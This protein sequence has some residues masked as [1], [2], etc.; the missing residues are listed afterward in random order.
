MKETIMT[1]A[2]E[3]NCEA[4][5]QQSDMLQMIFASLPVGIMV[6]DAEG[7]LLFFNPAA[8]GIL[9]LGVSDIP[10]GRHAPIYGW[11]LPDQITVL[12]NERLPLVR[13]IRGETLADEVIFVRNL[14]HPEGT[15]IRVS[16]G[17]LRNRS[18]TVSGGVVMLHDFSKEREE[19]Q[20]LLLLSEAAEQSTDS[21]I[22][23]D[24]QGVIQYVNPAFELTTGYNREEVLGQTP[25]ILKSGAQ[26]A[27]F[28]R[29]MWARLGEGLS[30]SGTVVNRKKSG[31]LYWAQQAITPLRDESANLTHFVSVLQDVTTQRK[32]QEQELHL[33]LAREVQQRFYR[34]VPAVPGLDIG[35]AADPAYETGG[36]YFDFI[37][38]AD[39]SLMIAVGD[40]RGHGFGSALIMALTRAYLRS[41]AALPLELHEILER[42]NASL[43]KDLPHGQFVTLALARL[44]AGQRMLSFA[45]AGHVPGVVLHESGGVKAELASTGLPLGLFAENKCTLQPAIQLEPGDLVVLVTDGAAES[46]ADDGAEFGSQRVVEYIRSHR[47]DPAQHIANGI[48]HAARAHAKDQPQQDDI[49]SVV[50][51]I[52]GSSAGP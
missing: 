40:V 30:F 35:A 27:D 31:E 42:M 20:M 6:A 39:G 9:G 49:T 51:K 34:T 36:D 11:F 33:K 8:E 43:L 32:N 22:L 14:Q 24:R 52:R 26:D 1:L 15:W 7:H 44:H 16:G 46:A 3:R 4:L 50:I 28:Y 23:T 21:I 47:H 48:Y 37:F 38:M 25:R 13:A 45:S 10:P 2:T 19:L 41:F 17:P 29:Q 12:P 5:A 18:G